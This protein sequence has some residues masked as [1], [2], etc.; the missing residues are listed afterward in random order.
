MSSQVPPPRRRRI[1]GERKGRPTVAESEHGASGDT[2]A[3]AAS[4]VATRATVPSAP[5]TPPPPATV[6]APGRAQGPEAGAASEPREPARGVPWPVPAVLALVA[7]LLLALAAGPFVDG[8]GWQAFRTV[9]GQSEVDQA[10]RTAPA[11]AERAAEAVLSYDYKTLEADR[12]AAARLMT[13]RYRKEYLPTFD[14]LVAKLAPEQKAHVEASVRASGVTAAGADRVEVLLF[15]NQTTRST[16]HGGE[17]QVALNRVTFSMVRQDNAWRV[18]D[19]K[20]L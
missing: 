13:P 19:I 20:P 17:P 6:M 4:A 14:A 2:D 11:A 1:A 8:M 5:V 7:V 3:P 16:A 18:D 12:D 15:V 10:R 9:Q